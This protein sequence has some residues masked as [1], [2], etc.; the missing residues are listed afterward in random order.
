MRNVPFLKCPKQGDVMIVFMKVFFFPFQDMNYFAICSHAFMGRG[1]KCGNFQLPDY[2]IQ[3]TNQGR[4]IDWQNAIQ[5]P[6]TPYFS[7]V[8]QCA[9]DD[10]LTPSLA[11]LQLEPTQSPAPPPPPDSVRMPGI[12]H[13]QQIYSGPDWPT[14]ESKL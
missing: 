11:D 12:K 1:D 6:V 9:P 7:Y 10:M 8:L 13:S 3:K 4:K 2:N 14:S 5:S